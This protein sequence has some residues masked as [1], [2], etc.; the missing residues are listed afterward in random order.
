MSDELQSIT[1]SQSTERFR[2]AHL[3][4]LLQDWWARLRGRSADLLSYEEVRAALQAR[5]GI[6]LPGTQ[7]VPLDKIVGSV[8]RYRD[9]TQAFLPRN[10]ALFERWRRVDA[11]MHGPTGVP[12]VELYQVGDLYFVRDGN[13]RVSVARARGDKTIEAY[14]TKVEVPFPV[15][16]AN[17][18]ELSAWLTEAGHRLFLERTRLQE[19]FPDADVRLTEPGRYRLFDEQIAVHRYFLGKELQREIS[20]EEAVRSWYENV[21]LP[22]TREIRASGIMKEFP[23]RTEADLYLWICQHREELREK[24]NLQLDEKAAVST[25]ASMYSEK[26]LSQA[27]KEA[28]LAVARVAAGEDILI[29][30]PEK[31]AAAA[32]TPDANDASDQHAPNPA[33][34]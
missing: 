7:E 24:Y 13:H 20:Y 10:E 8:G 11:A 21:F 25:F 6:T 26:P 16:A 23:K 15:E 33:G 34:V 2:K 12:P 30:L 9:F 5:E 22:L 31:A 32:E 14:V 29:G 18:A 3:Q 27:L 19:Y 1:L 28:R 17:A 4:A